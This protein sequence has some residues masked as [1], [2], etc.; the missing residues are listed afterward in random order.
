MHILRAADRIATAWKNGG[1]TTREIIA[2]PP[3]SGFDDFEWRL[4][5]AD[6]CASGPFSH[7]ENVNRYLAMIEGEIELKINSEPPVLLTPKD[8]PFEFCAE[9]SVCATL[10]SPKAVD[11]NLMIRKG[12]KA[13]QM[14]RHQLIPDVPFIAKAEITL[15]FMLN[16]VIA[17]IDDKS[18]DLSAYDLI[19]LEPNESITIN[20]H[21]ADIIYC[22]LN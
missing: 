22:E 6:I 10:M 8:V 19:R 13:A 17:K 18:Y 15:F 3:N 2:M 4:S 21:Q 9:Q 7:F 12:S 16:S 11:L 1:G 20:H 5:M 14:L